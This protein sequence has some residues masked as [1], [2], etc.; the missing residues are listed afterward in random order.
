MKSHLWKFILLAVLI[1]A[2]IAIIRAQNNTPWQQNAGRIFGTE[3][4]ISYQ[5]EHDLG[6]E[7]L[8]VLQQVD[9]T[10]SMFN[11]A[12]I[13]SAVN[14]NKEVSVNAM[15]KDVF[16]IAQQVA[17]S[18]DGAFDPTIAPLVNAWGFGFKSGITPTPEVVDSLLKTVGFATVRI[19]NDRVVKDNPQTMIDF[20]AVAKGYACDAVA[21]LLRQND[22][23]NM[24]VE[25]GGEVVTR[26]RN[27]E[28]SPWRIG[29]NKPVED[30]LQTNNDVQAILT[31][32]D[33]A[34]ATSG[35]YRNFYYSG[36][37]RYAHTIDPHTGRP[38]QHSLLSATVVA[39][40]CALADAYATAFMVV[41]LEKAKKL[42]KKHP[43]L[44]A[45]LIYSDTDNTLKVWQSA[46]LKTE[47]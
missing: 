15:F 31:L 39:P 7:I 42:L 22:V 4:H 30:S 25:I 19:T 12:S 21:K 38:V 5:C 24:M 43:E 8:A 29:V 18:T 33:A 9:T 41:G 13:V 10:L 35:N 2:S 11:E 16:S 28:N 36:G 32:T 46:R 47:N 6:N 40:S 45:Y 20:S 17:K 3:Y 1:A 23:Q 26:G 44:K 37:K 14:Q 34:L 27:R